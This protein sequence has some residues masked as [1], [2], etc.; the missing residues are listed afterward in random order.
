MHL[1]STTEMKPVLSVTYEKFWKKYVIPFAKEK[2]FSGNWFKEEGGSQREATL[3]FDTKPSLMSHNLKKVGV[4]ETF[5]IVVSGIVMLDKHAAA[6]S[7]SMSNCILF[8][9]FISASRK[10]C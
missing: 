5:K 1:V 7:C 3:K 4:H 9:G 10:V 2:W 6:L 8:T